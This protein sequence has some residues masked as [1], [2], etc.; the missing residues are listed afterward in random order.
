M[1]FLRSLVSCGQGE[2]EHSAGTRDE[3]RLTGDRCQI[4]TT[5]SRLQ[6]RPS[7][8]PGRW[9]GFFKAETRRQISEEGRDES[10]G[11]YAP[12]IFGAFVPQP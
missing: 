8:A 1:P 6:T 7:G 9:P 10:P 2:G 5:Q 12:C 4:R 11:S 3:L